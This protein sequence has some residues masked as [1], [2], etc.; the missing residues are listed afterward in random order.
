MIGRPYGSSKM[1]F[2]KNTET[3]STSPLDELGRKIYGS[4]YW[5]KQETIHLL[6][7]VYDM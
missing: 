7:K 6:K 2:N 1:V 5:S 3:S 4:K